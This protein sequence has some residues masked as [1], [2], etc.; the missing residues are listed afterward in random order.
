MKI[1]KTILLAGVSGSGKSTL[2][3][4]LGR[5]V[6]STSAMLRAR[7]EFKAARAS[8]ESLF[9]LGNRLD[10]DWPH[11]MEGDVQAARGRGVVVDCIRSPTQDEVW[12]LG[13]EVVTV[14]VVCEARELARRHAARRT[15]LPKHPVYAFGNPDFVWRSDLVP[16]GQAVAAIRSMSGGGFAD[17]VVGAQYGSEGKGKLCALLAEQYDVLVRS[18]GPNAGHWVREEGSS[19]VREVGENR[20]AYEYCFHSIPSGT[21][22]NPRAK[23]MI[24]AGAAFSPEAF[25]RE[26]METGC[27]ER[28]TI[29]R[30]AMPIWKEDVLAE[31]QHNYNRDGTSS[32]VFQ[33][34]ST[35]QGVG[36]A[37]RRRIKRHVMSRMEAF[38]NFYGHVS[39]LVLEEL[40]Q[41][42]GVMLEGTQGSGLSMYHGPY[43]FVTSRDTNV[44]GM[45]A[46]VG[47]PPS[48]VRD[49]WMVVRSLPI[50]TGGNSGPMHEELTW[51]QVESRLGY[52]E[53]YL[54][55]RE[56]TST[57]N[58]IRRVGEFDAT[59]FRMACRINR[60]T[61]LFLTFAD[62]ISPGVSGVVN[63]WGLGP[64]VEAFVAMLEAIAECPV[65]GVSTGRTNREVAWRPGYEPGVRQ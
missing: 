35:G 64:E 28:L 16:V 49:V 26:V 1:R 50:R 29:D 6:I 13:G 21:R 55:G 51:S 63:W 30:N 38:R 58:R 24:A 20:E 59:Q 18:G 9:A 7:P 14:N 5:E 36:E 23:V 48:W 52:P 61:K 54:M 22:A 25:H 17:V 46:E 37:L 3:R 39:S 2:A 32:L 62:Y 40:E 47:V 65:A 12:R 33:I 56:K 8:D 60:P 27:A 4:M 43:P 53:G 19:G 41:G 10:E 34:G 45:L 15:A 42:S 44:S 57:T 31:N 11:W